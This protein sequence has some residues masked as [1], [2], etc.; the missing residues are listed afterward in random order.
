MWEFAATEPAD[1]EDVAALL[2]QSFGVSPDNPLLDRSSLKWKYYEDGPEWQG[3]RSYA[4]R[5]GKRL[6]AH[7]AVW[8]FQIRI[9]SCLRSGIGFCDWASRKRHPGVG[10]SLLKRLLSLTHLGLVT[11]GGAITRQ[12]LPRI[13]FQHWADRAIYSKILRP[14]RQF[15]T[16]TRTV[17]WKELVRLGRNF[18]WSRRWPGVPGKRRAAAGLPASIPRSCCLP[19]GRP[20]SQSRDSA[21]ASSEWRDRFCSAHGGSGSPS[22]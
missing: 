13:G 5:Q 21:H 3:S 10:I 12:I 14:L 20:R 2:Q 6:V 16:R 8:S 1:L 18:A 17:R 7:A 15:R 11:G 9:S 4:L 19:H 22:A